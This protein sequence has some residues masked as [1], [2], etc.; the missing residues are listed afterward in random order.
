MQRIDN[1]Q[2]LA[3]DPQQGTQV[4]KNLTED[5]SLQQVAEQFETLF[6]QMVLKNMRSASDAIAGDDGMFNSNEQQMYRDM[7]D[8]QMAQHMAANSQTGLAVQ[9]VRQFSDNVSDSPANTA[10]NFSPPVLKLPPETVADQ[11]YQDFSAMTGSMALS[12]PLQRPVV[13]KENNE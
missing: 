2:Q 7:H 8:S 6:F 12:Q 4:H 10:E 3:F 13:F 9:I 1:S 5:Q 11:Q